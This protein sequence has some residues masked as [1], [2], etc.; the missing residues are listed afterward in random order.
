MALELLILGDSISAGYGLKPDSSWVTL[1]EQ[2]LQQQARSVQ[3]INAS[4]SGE[5]TSG[6]RTRLPSLLQR[7]QPGLVIIE[8]GGNDGLRGTPLFAVEA[9][10]EALIQ[11]SH[12]AGAEVLLL[13]MRIPPNYGRR[14]AEGFVE[15]FPR[16]A[17]RHQIAYHPFFL[18]GVGGVSELMQTD[19]IHPNEQ[20]QPLLVDNIWPQ[21]ESL[22]TRLER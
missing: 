17:E 2:R 19:G 5:T 3:V 8:L 22:L 12:Q 18:D 7:H 6:G 9:N 10:L 20:A 15:I 21:L 1:L 16:V 11:Q 4:I 13:G 14:Y